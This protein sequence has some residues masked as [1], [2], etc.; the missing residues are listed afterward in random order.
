M[1]ATYNAVQ[2]RTVSACPLPPL[3]HFRWKWRT[4]SS[5]SELFFQTRWQLCAN[6]CIPQGETYLPRASLAEIERLESERE[7][8]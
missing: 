8:G 1:V 5:C 7:Q 2:V 6:F 3:A 4:T